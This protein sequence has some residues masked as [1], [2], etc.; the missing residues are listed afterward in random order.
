MLEILDPRKITPLE[1][2]QKLG[3][4]WNYVLDYAWADNRIKEYSKGRKDLTALDVG[5]GKSK[6]GNHIA[7]AYGIDVKGTDRKPH[8]TVEIVGKFL[9]LTFLSTYDI[10]FWMSSIEHNST[11]RMKQ[12]YLK[13]M[14][15]LKVGGL[16]LA[17]IA[18][19][20][21]T[22][23]FPQAKQTNLSVQDASTIFD[24]S[25]I[26]GN[27]LDCKSGYRANI[28]GLK[29]KYTKRFKQFT[30]A[31]PAYIVGAISKVK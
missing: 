31:D 28:Y 23:W 2:Q 29:D 20:E 3:K 17:T 15:L 9:D 7:T 18:L 27:F 21:G 12:L 13:S 5:C 22:Y 24:V 1:H 6:F 8:D 19:S 26:T 10:I 4:G 11:E 14:S 30:V 25:I 16:F